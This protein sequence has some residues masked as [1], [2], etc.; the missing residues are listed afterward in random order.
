[1]AHYRVTIASFVNAVITECWYYFTVFGKSLPLPDPPPPTS[2]HFILQGYRL[3]MAHTVAQSAHSQH[4][5]LLQCL[6]A[7][8]SLMSPSHPFFSHQGFMGTGCRWHSHFRPTSVLL[9]LSELVFSC[10]L[11]H[12]QTVSGHQVSYLQL[13]N[14]NGTDCWWHNT[15]ALLTHL[16]AVIT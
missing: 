12:S 2:P 10:T 6:V 11:F 8:N 15:V 5:I 4:L 16:N 3:S 9:P 14:H 7:K 1:M 13:N